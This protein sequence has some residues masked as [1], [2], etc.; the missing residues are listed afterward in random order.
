M[1]HNFEV[2]TGVLDLLLCIIV[3]E[4]SNSRLYS[5]F[6]KSQPGNQQQQ[7]PP[8]QQQNA[9]YHQTIRQEP[10]RQPDDNKVPPAVQL[11][12]QERPMGSQLSQGMGTSYQDSIPPRMQQKHNHHLASSSR[13][14]SAQKPHIPPQRDPLSTQS[15]VVDDERKLKSIDSVNSFG[16]SASGS[17]DRKARFTPVQQKPALNDYSVS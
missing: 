17:S 5:D 13:L 14:Q 9:S 16:A 8:Q 15:D 3:G 1:Y 4:Q 11:E 10:V 2:P 12:A 6:F 7:Q